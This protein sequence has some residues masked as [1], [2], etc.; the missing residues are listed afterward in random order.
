M[1]SRRDQ[2][3]P[4]ERSSPPPAGE[5]KTPRCSAQR[6]NVWR[7]RSSGEVLTELRRLSQAGPV[8]R[9]QM[10]AALWHAI[11]RHWPSLAAARSAAGLRPPTLPRK[12]TRAT[13]IAALRAAQSAGVKMTQQGISDEDAAFGGTGLVSAARSNF[14]SFAKARDA[15]GIPAPPRPRCPKV[16]RWDAPLVLSEIRRRHREGET[17]AMS[18][19]RGS[20]VIT[21]CRFFGTWQEAIEAAGFRYEDIRLTN[22][23]SDADLIA[24]LRQQAVDHPSWSR[25]ALHRSRSGITIVQRFGSIDNALEAAGIRDWPRTDVRQLLT[26]DEVIARLRQRLLTNCDTSA[27][28]LE[29]DESPLYVSILR[30]FDSLWDALRAAGLPT[31]HAPASWTAA[32]ILKLLR[33]RHALGHSLA[34]KDLSQ[35][36][37]QGLKGAIRR[38]F[39]NLQEACRQAGVPHQNGRSRNASRKRTA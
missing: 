22:Q 24:W 38:L 1:P 31:A 20:L 5:R 6:E 2:N 14:G 18:K 10:P 36:L 19:V 4:K 33:T 15:A 29:A 39:G 13:V 3:Q 28:A 21:A 8:L 16:I 32:N 12:W 25:T 9:R 7:L 35:E 11:L 17:L 27:A 23:Y 34:A 30:R 26:R 37:G